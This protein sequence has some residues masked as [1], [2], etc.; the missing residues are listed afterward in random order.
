MWVLSLL[1]VSF[2]CGIGLGSGC[3]CCHA[4][5]HT[6]HVHLFSSLPSPLPPP[7]YTETTVP[8]Y[9]GSVSFS[10]VRMYSHQ[11]T[12]VV[13]LCISGGV[14]FFPLLLGLGRSIFRH[15]PG[16]EIILVC[17]SCSCCCCCCCL[18][19]FSD[20]RDG[21]VGLSRWLAGWLA[22]CLVEP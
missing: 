18:S 2:F 21:W 6:I 1:F 13:V 20:R 10:L 4:H 17:C 19:L 22:G 12:V 9:L 3:C 7:P 11:L 5:T 16:C 15:G 8:G 14:F